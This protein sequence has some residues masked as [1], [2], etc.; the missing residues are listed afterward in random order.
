[1][2]GC[3]D[4]GGWCSGSGRPGQG[5]PLAVLTLRVRP[6]TLP[7]TR[8]RVSACPALSFAG[9]V[10]WSLRGTSVTGVRGWLVRAGLLAAGAAA[11]GFVLA[12]SASAEEVEPAS[13]T[14]S[15]PVVS[16]SL[17]A[18]SA[19][20]AL[21]GWLAEGSAM[22]EALAAEEP[23]A[24]GAEASEG[25]EVLLAEEQ[26]AQPAAPKLA[27]Y[28]PAEGPTALERA[29]GSL[30]AG[31]EQVGSFLGRVL[32]V[33]QVGMGSGAGGPVLLLGV[34]GM[35][36]ALARHRILGI[37]GAS[38]ENVPRFLYAWELTPPG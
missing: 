14:A 4:G 19:P 29:L 16:M 1:M 7:S 26:V 22:A 21:P 35:A 31:S 5:A 3:P 2:V 12:A 28:V 18:S 30:R 38:D 6:G 15:T 13:A 9:L 23:V 33:C 11:V 25:A 37:R 36:V 27:P 17:P 24:L 20:P 8:S 10:D 32:T 34:L